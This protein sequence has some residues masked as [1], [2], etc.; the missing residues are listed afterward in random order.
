MKD[1]KKNYEGAGKFERKIACFKTYSNFTI[2]NLLNKKYSDKM[3]RFG[4]EKILTEQE[5]PKYFQLST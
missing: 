2:Y 3:K 4:R 5:N 1:V